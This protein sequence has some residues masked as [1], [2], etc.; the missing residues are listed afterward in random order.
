MNKKKILYDWFFRSGVI[1]S[2]YELS[3]ISI[4]YNNTDYSYMTDGGVLRPDI[5]SVRTNANLI[6]IIK[7]SDN[8]N[9][10][11]GLGHDFINDKILVMEM[12]GAGTNGIAK[13]LSRDGTTDRTVS[14]T[15]SHQ[16]ISYDPV[17][18]IIYGYSG[19]GVIRLHNGT[20]GSVIESFSVAAGYIGGACHYDFFTGKLYVTD[21]GSSSSDTQNVLVYEKVS[22]T[23]TLTET[24]WFKCGEGLFQDYIKDK[25]VFW[26][27][28]AAGTIDNI[29]IIPESGELI[30]EQFNMPIATD[31]KE[32]LACDP[33]DG[34]IRLNIDQG[35][36]GGVTDGNCVFHFDPRRDYRKYWRFPDMITY[37]FFKLS[38]ATI[39]GIYNNQEISASDFI[40]SPVLDCASHTEQQTVGNWAIDEDHEIEYR[41]SA[42]APSTT[43]ITDDYLGDTGY[44]DG[45]GTNDGW[46]STTPSAWSS[47]IPTN[48]YIQ[49]RI[50]PLETDPVVADWLP[51]DLGSDLVLWMEFDAAFTA[52][53]KVFNSTDTSLNFTKAFNK[54]NPG[55]NDSDVVTTTTVQPLWNAATSAMRMGS[56][57]FVI[58][59]PALLLAQQEGEINMVVAK[60]AQGT[61]APF[62]VASESGQAGVSQFALEHYSSS[63]TAPASNNGRGFRQSD[64]S[65][66]VVAKSGTAADSSVTFKMITFNSDG[67][68]FRTFVDKVEQSVIMASGS[69]TGQWWADVLQTTP[70]LRLGRRTAVGGSVGSADFRA[71][72]WTSKAL[73]T[74]TR[75]N[76]Y[77]YYVRKG[78]R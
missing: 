40:T 47:S 10:N 76:I 49:F 13:F 26:D 71:I 3:K 52:V 42:S 1:S 70:E 24:K 61:P 56:R 58:N 30:V 45:N 18:N 77:D 46:G 28:S 5:T 17:N 66:A 14:L 60:T 48:R 33:K 15:G 41:G 50:N 78:F 38:G 2:G 36:H 22:G 35:F 29:T 44:Y 27:L 73:S 19:A 43:R 69:N 9:P 64:G 39:S 75:S 53:T 23:W 57:N 8:A 16:G 25:F 55:T 4:Q 72:V 67:V 74:Q 31:F 54:A 21:T 59:S 37:D 11:T 65:A 32:G 63:D 7:V 6:S 68:T 62:I 12:Q 34:T 20:T 51:S